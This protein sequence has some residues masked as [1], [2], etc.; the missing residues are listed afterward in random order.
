MPCDIGAAIKDA[1][2]TQLEKRPQGEA[3]ASLARAR[4]AAAT[5]LMQYGGRGGVF[6]DPLPDQKA[7]PF[8]RMECADRQEDE[9]DAQYLD[10]AL[11]QEGGE[12][13]AGVTS[14]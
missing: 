6:R 13:G 4:A 3:M 12:T 2:A 1:R 7:I 9:T 8:T 5:D 14:G 10:R 11:A